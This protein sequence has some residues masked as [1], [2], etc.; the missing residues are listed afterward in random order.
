MPDELSAIEAH[1]SL[2]QMRES[3]PVLCENI[4]IQSALCAAAFRS[5]QKEGF[6]E[7]HALQIICARGWSLS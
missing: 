4:A 5:L 7:A 3:L 1:E 2:R 6:S